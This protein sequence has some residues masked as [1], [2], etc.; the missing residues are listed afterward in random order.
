MARPLAVKAG[1]EIKLVPSA[2]S[3]RFVR[4]DRGRLRQILLN[5]LANG[6]KYNRESGQVTITAANGTTGLEM[7]QSHIPDLILLDL[8]LPDM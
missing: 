6:I 3:A 5:L 8:E 4:A 2:Q 7:A 1:I